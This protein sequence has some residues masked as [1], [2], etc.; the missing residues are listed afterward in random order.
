[1][2]YTFSAWHILK[3]GFR[4]FYLLLAACISKMRILAAAIDQL[5]VRALLLHIAAFDHRDPV[6][7]PQ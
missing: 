3:P 5:L 7:H 4:P 1:M 6:R 2:A